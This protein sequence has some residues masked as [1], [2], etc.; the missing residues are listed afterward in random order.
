[1]AKH[2]RGD[3]AGAIAGYKELLNQ[4]PNHADALHLLGLAFYQQGENEQA[5]RLID[6]AIQSDS[7]VALF[8]NHYG[9]VLYALSR[10]EEALAA[11]DAALKL[12][13]GFV[14]AHNNR[15]A[16]LMGAGRLKEALAA[17]N[18]A[19]GLEPGNQE[20]HVNRA[21]V[22][23]ELGHLGESVESFQ[24]A[25]AIDPCLSD[26]H[27]QLGNVLR[28][29]GRMQDA[30]SAYD[31]ALKLDDKDA[32][33]YANR[34][35]VLV[36]LGRL[37]EAEESYRKA[38]AVDQD[39]IVTL[40]NWASL[41]LKQGKSREA[42]CVFETAL[43][44]NPKNPE[45]NN[46]YGAALRDVGEL[47]EAIAAFKQA[48]TSEPSYY[49]AHSNRIMALHYRE[50]NP[51]Q[52]IA[53]AIRQFAA[54]F[55][56]E[57]ICRP[58]MLARTLRRKMRIGYVSGDFRE[59]PV[60]YFLEGAMLHHD[61]AELEIYCYSNNRVRDRLTAR[62]Q[63]CANKWRT[64][65]NLPDKAALECIRT[66]G[67]DILVDL[68][69]HTANNRLSLFALR[70]A[71][72]QV[73]WLGY[74]GTTGLKAIDFILADRFV[75]RDGE[76]E[77]FSERV[78]R[79]PESYLCF[80]P[81]VT[82]SEIDSKCAMPDSV[83]FASFNN[84]LKLS[85]RTIRLWSRVLKEV[86]GSNLLIRDKVLAD[87]GVR[88][89]VLG[90][91]V[92]SGTCPEQL[93]MES[94]VSREEYLREYCDVDISLSPTPFGGG[95]TTAE[96]LWMGVPVVFLSGGTWAGRIGESILRTVGLPELVAQDEERYVGIATALAGD[97]KR[98]RE[99]RNDL[100]GMVQNS[101]LC[102]FT[103]FTYELERAYREMWKDITER[104]AHGYGDWH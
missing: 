8:Y 34:G 90:E 17:F 35:N 11:F 64:I 19:V 18:N 102:D 98:R 88:A 21:K 56:Q 66:D 86:P 29:L 68:S 2:R 28:M 57:E 93:V 24:T 74:F 7:Q 89:K 101:P 83:T 92:K 30:L 40:N 78:W 62:L 60:G 43:A 41:L 85:E 3:L 100:R 22:L 15:G 51:D 5:A 71:P 70:P 13:P 46:N 27:F 82:R 58:S 84:I 99:L 81:P 53:R 33:V 20:G 36:E 16:V 91:F 95:T 1:M 94:S 87:P 44:I 97:V 39:H 45:V 72:V 50:E 54:R 76:E 67:I 55:E 9:L 75:I 73:T 52:R 47:N 31:H 26:A 12:N 37:K 10:T 42:I 80:T 23:G 4:A 59:H 6:R 65:E 63:A 38:L 79:L 96:A 104:V 25:I 48:I 61:R 14:K 77:K 49:Q 32:S 69:G 103:T